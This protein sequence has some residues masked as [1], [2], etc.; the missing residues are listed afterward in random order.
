[1]KIRNVL[2]SLLGV[3]NRDLNEAIQAEQAEGA[4]FER[5]L[6]PIA[7][8]KDFYL[9]QFYKMTD[10]GRAIAGL[11]ADWDE[12]HAY[13]KA[14]FEYFERKAVIS[15][16]PSLG[17]DS[18]NGVGAHRYPA[19]AF[20]AGMNELFERDSF[21]RHWYSKTPFSKIEGS[22]TSSNRVWVDDMDQRGYRTLFCKTHLGFLATTLV[23]LID[24]KTGGFALGLSSGRGGE[25]D[26]QK[27]FMEAATN[28]FFGNEGKQNEELIS[29]VK[30]HGI[31]SLIDHRTNWLLINPVPSWVLSL[32]ESTDQQIR[33]G[34]LRDPK[35]ER[36][37]L[38]MA[39]VPVVGARCE[40]SLNLVLGLPN[41]RDLAILRRSQLHPID[42]DFVPHPIP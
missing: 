28:L 41:E 23:F 5:L 21:L 11:G 26:A 33:V 9:I 1:M 31:T 3:T 42:D 10:R 13:R 6:F 40:D 14:V 27:A 19:L 12:K 39:P 8:L 15:L 38:A 4:A 16:G 30:V 36:V 35:V 22:L 2:R 24:R 34:K 32:V 18:T 20:R 7:C 17:F 25:E 37:T 29:R